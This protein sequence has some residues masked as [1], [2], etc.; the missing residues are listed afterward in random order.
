MLLI[1]I[2][3]TLV[4][5]TLCDIADLNCTYLDTSGA[6]PKAKFS[7]IAVACSNVLADSV[8]KTLYGA[9]AAVANSDNDREQK[10]W[11]NGQARDEPTVQAAVSTCPRHCGYCCLT[12]EYSC[13]N[14][15]FPRISCSVITPNMCYSSAWRNI[16]EEDCPNVCGFCNSGNCFDVAPNCALDISICR[17]VLMQDFVKENC[18]RTCDY[19][20]Q[21]SA[22]TATPCGSD[23]NCVNW[24]KN[25][26]CNS[27]FYTREQ[28]RQY[29]GTFCGL[30]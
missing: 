5:R 26:F 24:V 11:K 3:A 23:P 7:D 21:T 16:I 17:S 25:G 27:I 14:K 30:C 2:C 8:C 6:Q 22:T 1:I 9:N 28:K 15:Q 13:Q 12:P 18:R 4:C 10:C 20:S 19:C 29:C